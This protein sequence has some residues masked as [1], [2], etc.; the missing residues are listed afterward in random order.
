MASPPRARP[1]VPRVAAARGRAFVDYALVRRGVLADLAGGRVRREDVCDA[2]PLLRRAAL[3]LGTPAGYACPV[4]AR[5]RLLL[6]TW[7]YGD[8]LGASSGRSAFPGEVDEVAAEHAEVRVYVVE[9]CADC[10]WNHLVESYVV[11]H[12]QAPS[13]PRRRARV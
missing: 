9:V 4:C 2:D 1:P 12:G 10:G 3:T 6:S 13:R 7:R 11:G 5:E 8:E